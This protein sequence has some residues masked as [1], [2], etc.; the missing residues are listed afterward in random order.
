M[1]YRVIFTVDATCSVEVEA[2]SE[3]EAKEKAWE[4][5]SAPTVCHQCSNELEVGDIM[6]CIDVEEA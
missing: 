6:D 2:D 3:E 4:E 5:A 1:K